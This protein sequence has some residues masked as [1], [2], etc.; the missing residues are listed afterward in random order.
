VLEQTALLTLEVVEVG[1]LEKHLII[2]A[3]QVDQE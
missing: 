3:V 1:A 2:M